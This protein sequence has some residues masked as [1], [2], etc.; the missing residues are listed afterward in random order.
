MSYD[1]A[2]AVRPTFVKR[3][4]TMLIS[5]QTGLTQQEVLK[6]IQLLTDNITDHLAQGSAVTFRNFGTFE[7]RF[8]KP[9]VGRNPRKPEKSF[10]IPSRAEVRFSPGKDMKERVALISCE[11]MIR[12]P[13]RQG[14]PGV[15]GGRQ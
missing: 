1:S 6:I 3:D 5:D 10:V 4:L 7:P 13:L 15:S 11:T 12:I 14:K 8:S 9:K 2:P